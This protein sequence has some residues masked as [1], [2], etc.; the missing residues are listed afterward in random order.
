VNATTAPVDN[1]LAIRAQAALELRRRQSKANIKPESWERY[2]T[3][4]VPAFI[5]QHF[6]IPETNAPMQLYPSQETPLREALSRDAD[7]KFRYSTVVWSS[8]KKSAKSSIAAAVALWFCWQKP[9]STIKVIANDLKQADSRVAYYCRR[10]ILLHPEWRDLVKVINY[11]ITFPNHSTIEALPID[12]KG[13]AGGNDDLVIF[14]EL[15]G[16]NNKAS[17]TMWTEMT[18]SPMKYGQSMRWCETYAGFTGESPVLETLYENGVTNGTIIDADMEMYRH[19]RLFVLWNTK[20]RLPWQTTDYYKQ[21]DG[22]L[23]EVEFNRIHKNAWGTSTSAFI[24]S[25]W[26]ANCRHALPEYKRGESWVIALDAAISGDCFAMAGVTRDKDGHTVVRFAKKWKA[27]KGFEIQYTAPEGTDPRLSDTPEGELYRLTERHS[28]VE[29]CYDPYQLYSLC[30]SLADKLVVWFNEFNQGAPRLEAD[31]ALWD[32]IR[33]GNVWHDGSS[34]DLDEHLTNA[35]Q[36]NE[37]GKL[38][39]VKRK[40]SLKIDLAVSLSMAN[41][42]AKRLN[43]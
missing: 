13:E 36:Q 23:T 40:D 25:E 18:L 11:K 24:P 30:H 17:Q 29:I 20:P 38:R 14:S 8:I 28:V 1:S 7:G 22:E 9:W 21:E 3:S 37:N 41:Y 42:E 12:P 43:I 32:D 2:K 35:N 10:A 15:W 39:I 6:Y 34:P 26:W 27:E 5:Q 16:W 33:D 31:K 19:E 4:D